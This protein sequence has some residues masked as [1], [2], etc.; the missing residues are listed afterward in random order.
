MRGVGTCARRACRPASDYFL[1]GPSH[2]GVTFPGPSAVNRTNGDD[3]GSQTFPYPAPYGSEGTGES[4][5][6][7]PGGAN[8]VGDRPLSSVLDAVGWA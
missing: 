6:F 3:I 4:Y 2:D 7:H 8:V 1:K 5:S